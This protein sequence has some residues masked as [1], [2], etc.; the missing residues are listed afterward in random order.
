MPVPEICENCWYDFPFSKRGK[1]EINELLD[2]V[3][4][5]DISCSK[6]FSFFPEAHCKRFLI[7]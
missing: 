4:L 3:I 2:G 5:C 1:Y 6:V 7:G